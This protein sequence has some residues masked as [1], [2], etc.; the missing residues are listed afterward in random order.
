MIDSCCSRL[1][2][3]GLP[4]REDCRIKQQTGIS[5]TRQIKRLRLRRAQLLLR[6]TCWNVKE[7]MNQVGLS[8][9]SHFAKDYKKEFGESPTETRCKA[10]AVG[11]KLTPCQEKSSPCAKAGN[12]SPQ[13]ANGDCTPAVASAKAG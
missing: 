2:V 10:I 5:F 1:L 4:C 9:H 3:S 6:E 13:L 11:K 12:S 7:V 8:D